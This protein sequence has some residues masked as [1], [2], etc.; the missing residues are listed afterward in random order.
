MREKSFFSSAFRVSHGRTASPAFATSPGR[1]L[2]GVSFVSF[3]RRPFA[4][5][6]GSTHSRYASYPLSNLPLYLSTYSFGAWCGAWF[7]PGQSHMNQGLEGLLDF[8]SRI[9]CMA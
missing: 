9:I 8:W 4:I 6:R 3:G 5:M 7:A 1:G 2:I